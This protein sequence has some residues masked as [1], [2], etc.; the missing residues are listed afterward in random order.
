MGKIQLPSV[1]GIRKVIKTNQQTHAGTTIAEIGDGTITL[2]QLSALVTQV[3]LTQNNNGGGNIVG[4]AVP[5]GGGGSGATIVLGPGLAGGGP[6]VGNVP[7][8]ISAPLPWFD[9]DGGGGDGDPG[10]PGAPGVAGIAG[11]LG[12]AGPM[13]PAIFLDAEMGDDGPQGPP[14]L[15]GPIGLAGP[16]GPPGAI[17]V[18]A[19]SSVPV[20]NTVTNTTLETFFTSSYNIPAG[21]LAVG[22]VVRLKLFGTYSTGI[23]APSLTLRIYFGSTVMIASGTLTTVA[24]I[25]NDGWSAEGLF[26]VQSIGASG[27]VESQGVS[28]FATALT[29]ALIVNMDNTAPITVDT[30]IIENLRVSVQWGGTVNA[31]D[32]ITLREMTVEMLTVAGIPAPPPPPIFPVFFGEDGEDGF[33]GIPGSI[34]PQGIAGTGSTI[35]LPGTIGDLVYWWSSS[36]ILSSAGQKITRLMESTPWFGGTFAVNA[37]TVT[38]VDNSQLNGFNVLK[39]PPSNTAGTYTIQTTSLLSTATTFF[40]V[41]K[42]AS[43]PSAAGQAII[44]G[45]TNSLAFY[46]NTA[47]GGTACA[48]VKTGIAV[49]GT[50]SASWTTGTWF[51]VNAT[52]IS[53]TGAYAFR[54][55]RAAAGSGTSATTIAGTG[56][57]SFVGA[58]AATS[59]DTLNSAS[60]AEIII[61]NRVLTA[62]EITNVENYLNTKWGV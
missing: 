51:Q 47:S 17:L 29:T 60:L 13:G 41:I 16:S 24:N 53:G 1:G 34:G 6:L 27:T 52:Y 58:D 5:G 4:P 10:P 31:S 36:A 11:S 62:G 35:A 14:G 49:I 23:V 44:G 40:A 3:Q 54:Q 12:P 56:A 50:C 43:A 48:L 32:T 61:Y 25:T 55:G 33:I 19:N 22:A 2:A 26:T 38:T 57:T 20:G 9:S 59:T 30:T 7:I 42:P 18:Y 21:T 15:Q 28:E 46:L 8:R 45:L 37:G 39:F